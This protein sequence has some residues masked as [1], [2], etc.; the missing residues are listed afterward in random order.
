[1][2]VTTRRRRPDL[3]VPAP[4]DTTT[5]AAT[6]STPAVRQRG[7]SATS[8]ATAAGKRDLREVDTPRELRDRSASI[9]PAAPTSKEALSQQ[10]KQMEEHR[11]E[12][13]WTHI[14]CFL[15]DKDETEDMLRWLGRRQPE[16]GT[17]LGHIRDKCGGTPLHIAMLYGHLGMARR[18]VEEY[19]A[20]VADCFDG[21]DTT[22]RKGGNSFNGENALHIAIVQEDL[23]MARL[24]L[25]SDDGAHKRDMLKA[26]ATGRFFSPFAHEKWAEHSLEGCEQFSDT[27]RVKTLAISNM[28]LYYGELPLGFAVC[29][30]QRAMVVELLRQAEG[31]GIDDL[32]TWQD[33]YGN[34]V[35]HLCVVHNLPAMYE[36]L[37]KDGQLAKALGDGGQQSRGTRLTAALVAGQVK[38][39]EDARNNDDLLPLTLAAKIG[40]KRMF[41]KMVALEQKVMW[42]YPPITCVGHPLRHLD[43]SRFHAKGDAS[44]GPRCSSFWRSSTSRRGAI[45]IIMEMRHLHMLTLPVVA[46]LL[47]QKWECF[48]HREFTNARWKAALVLGVFMINS[49]IRSEKEYAHFGP[50]RRCVV[51]DPWACEPVLRQLLACEADWLSRDTLA[52]VWRAAMWPTD[53][54]L[55]LCAA[56]K[57]TH[58]LVR[59]QNEGTHNFFCEHAGSDFLENWMGV[60]TSFFVIGA[61]VAWWLTYYTTSQTAEA[62]AS[63]TGWAYMMFFLLGDKDTGPFVVMLYEM[64]VKDITRFISVYSVFLFGFAQAFFIFTMAGS[65]EDD[66]LHRGLTGFFLKVEA[67]FESTL[68]DVTVKD[69]YN[70]FEYDGGWLQKT[71]SISLFISFTILITVMLFNL[72]VAMMGSTY[73]EVKEKADQR[74]QLERARIIASVEIEMPDE[75]FEESENRYYVLIENERHLQRQALADKRVEPEKSTEKE[76]ADTDSDD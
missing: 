50:H 55:T 4:I 33:T 68:G 40:C 14:E 30:G 65:K 71:A 48:A 63:V 35:L 16:D 62:L 73:E 7:R 18:L 31:A 1:M 43:S 25:A 51:F 45:E 44:A 49:M 5:N 64:L 74:W 57:L 13:P 37:T 54:I 58:K 3:D 21:G 61:R 32:L 72:L 24:L 53:V 66:D 76:A 20:C 36:F 10:E 23:E 8:R 2:P 41:Q 28:H 75:Y 11:R 34:N 27:Q 26:L 56:K 52:L 38:A 12:R 6:S 46:D 70:G 19:P 42:V 60:A 17:G 59:F 9:D 22:G 39:M 67:L 29:T 69:Y 47:A 15:K